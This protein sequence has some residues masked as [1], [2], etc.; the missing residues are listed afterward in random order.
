MS[1]LNFT[2]KNAVNEPIKG[3]LSN[4]PEK[5]SIKEKI[6]ELK[7]QTFDIPIIINGNEIKKATNETKKYL[8]FTPPS[9]SIISPLVAI[10]I[11]VPKSGW[12]KTKIIGIIIKVNGTEILINEFTFSELKRW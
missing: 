8:I 6:N 2:I 12:D 5:K 11:D 4:S 10:N 3:Y 1:N 7:S 9:H